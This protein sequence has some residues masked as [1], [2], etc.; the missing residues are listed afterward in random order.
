M[1][2][3]SDASSPSVYVYMYRQIFEFGDCFVVWLPITELATV[4]YRQI[5]RL[6]RLNSCTCGREFLFIIYMAKNPD[7]AAYI[8]D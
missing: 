4:I 7:F 1:S 5:F 3:K 8:T 6:V 2:E